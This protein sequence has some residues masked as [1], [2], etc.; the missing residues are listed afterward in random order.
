M[1]N[2][3]VKLFIYLVSVY[4]KNIV[5]SIILYL[6]NILVNENIEYWFY[7]F[8]FRLRIYIIR[9]ISKLYSMLEDDKRYG[10]NKKYEF[11]RIERIVE[12]RW[13]VI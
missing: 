11:R 4:W 13:D 6:W 10:K 3:F 12:Y 1:L 8:I 9:I 2:W 7:E 5:L